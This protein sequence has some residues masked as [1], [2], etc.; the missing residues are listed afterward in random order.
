[1]RKNNRR[2]KMRGIQESEKQ[3]KEERR[4]IRKENVIEGMRNKE[5]KKKKD[6]R[7][8]IKKRKK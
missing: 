2:R 3:G 6:E 4:K 8:E 7:G 5:S 1:M